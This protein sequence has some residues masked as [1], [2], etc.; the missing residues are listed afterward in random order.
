MVNF[1]EAIAYCKNNPLKLDYSGYPNYGTVRIKS[2]MRNWIVLYDEFDNITDVKFAYKESRWVMDKA[3]DY[4]IHNNIPKTNIM[5]VLEYINKTEYH[6]PKINLEDREEVK[7]FATSFGFDIEFSDNE[8]H[9]VIRYSIETEEGTEVVEDI[10]Y[11]VNVIYLSSDIARWRIECIENKVKYIYRRNYRFD[12]DE[13]KGEEYWGWHRSAPVR[14]IAASIYYCYSKNRAFA[15]RKAERLALKNAQK[16]VYHH[17]KEKNNNV[18]ESNQ[19]I[20][21]T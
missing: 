13:R 4:K 15:K 17:I 7:E 16:P 14:N 2:P 18:Q 5:A 6:I 10:P 3:R 11:E 8:D 20:A 9:V 21:S 12:Y 1:S 19:R